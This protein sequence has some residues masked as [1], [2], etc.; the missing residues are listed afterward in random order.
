MNNFDGNPEN[1]EG[2]S[3]SGQMHGLVLLDENNDV[4]RHAILW[5]D[6]RTTAEWK[7]IYNVVGKERLLE[8]TKNHAL[9]GLTQLKILLEKKHETKIFAKTL[10]F[11][12]SII[13]VK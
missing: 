10:K 12:F 3:F 9:E 4:L 6:N 5:N 11:I 13:N 8:I 7:D 2:I 1:I